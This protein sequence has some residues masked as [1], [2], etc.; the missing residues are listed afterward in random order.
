MRLGEMRAMAIRN[1][2]A[3]KGIPL[4]AMQVISYGEER[5]PWPRTPPATAGP[6]TAVW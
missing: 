5:R 1:Y 4:H 3:E 2:L 6:R